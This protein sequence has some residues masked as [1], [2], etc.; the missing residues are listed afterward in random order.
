M[1][2]PGRTP[3]LSNASK[4]SY[5]LP[6]YQPP[7]TGG[8]LVTNAAMATTGSSRV[9]VAFPSYEHT[10]WLATRVRV[11]TFP[12]V[13]GIVSRPEPAQPT[14]LRVWPNPCTD[15]L[16]VELAS[17]AGA[18]VSL[19]DLSGREVLAS[20]MTPG[21]SLELDL[22]GLPGGMYTIVCSTASSSFSSRFVR[23]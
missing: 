4:G 3:S 16:T 7:T 13:L 20:G 5:C 14:V 23:L 19:F 15:V 21:Q 11:A 2:S 17:P 22:S 10:P 12:A 6:P 9:G 18:S 8:E 1:F